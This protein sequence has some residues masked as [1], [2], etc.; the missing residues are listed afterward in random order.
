[1]KIIG[2][3]TI[4]TT[5]TPDYEMG[6][7]LIGQREMSAHGVFGW[8]P[9]TIEKHKVT[10]KWFVTSTTGGYPLDSH[11]APLAVPLDTTYTLLVYLQGD[12][13]PMR[14]YKT[15]E[16]LVGMEKRDVWLIK[17]AAFTLSQS[18]IIQT[19]YLLSEL[20]PGDFTYVAFRQISEEEVHI[21]LRNEPEPIL[22][23]GEE[24]E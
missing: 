21:D 3:T 5:L 9:T 2:C 24:E 17:S 10:R 22:V 12:Y 13:L 7:I 8:H 23:P 20:K 4:L 1:M 15:I 18:P 19:C 6:D 16:E 14:I 11:V